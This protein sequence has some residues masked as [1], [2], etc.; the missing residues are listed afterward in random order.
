[1]KIPWGVLIWRLPKVIYEVNMSCLRIDIKRLYNS[2]TVRI[3]L[4]VLFFL[5]IVDPLYSRFLTLD[6]M[7]ASYYGINAYQYWLFNFPGGIGFK[8]YHALFLLLPVLSTG[9]IL[10]YDQK[11]SFKIYNIVKQGRAIYLTSK[12]ISVFLVTMVNSIVSFSINILIT[13]SIFPQNSI[14]TDV[15]RMF[16]PI[17]H[18]AANF[19]YEI[20]PVL[21][22][23]FFAFLN[24]LALSVLAALTVI[25]HMIFRFPN[26]YVAFF[27][28]S[29]LFQLITY[30]SDFLLPKRFVLRN[31]LQPLNS[32]YEG[33]AQLKD[34]LLVLSGY[35]ILEILLFTIAYRRNRDII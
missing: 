3:V 31:F 5:A 13:F 33:A 6:S 32:C 4:G 22:A 20:S 23:V 8:V 26:I 19:F 1:M 12:V 7:F 10:F 30:G 21:S 28:P 35:F 14:M 34:I 24:S 9:F 17:E 15:Y 18:S 27:V 2:I 11:T 16:I 25:I 29:I